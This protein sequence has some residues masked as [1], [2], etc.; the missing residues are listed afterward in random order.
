VCCSVLQCVTVCCS[1]LQCVAVCCS[2]LQFVAV[3]CS[4]LQCV[5]VCVKTCPSRFTS[6]TFSAHESLLQHYAAH[7][8]TLQYTATHCNTLQHTATHCNTGRF[9]VTAYCIWSVISSFSNLNR[10]S[11]SLG[12]FYHVPL[13][14]AQGDWDWRLRL[15]NIP[16]AIDL[17]LHNS[18]SICRAAQAQTHRVLQCVVECCSVLQCVAVCCSVLQCVAVCCSVL[19]CTHRINA[20]KEP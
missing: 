11:S 18:R 15:N 7:C 9:C 19:Q 6:C 16:N 3:C 14:R 12:L 13:K 8:N 4:L 1:V 20:S 17:Y 2:V 10:S 5:A